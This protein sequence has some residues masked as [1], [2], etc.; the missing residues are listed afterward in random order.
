MSIGRGQV[1]TKAKVVPHYRKLVAIGNARCDAYLGAHT[2]TVD[3][4]GSTTSKV[5]SRKE[6]APV[7]PTMEI[8]IARV[9]VQHSLE[10]AIQNVN[11][12]ILLDVSMY[13]TALKTTYAQKWSQTR[14]E[15]VADTLNR[16][17]EQT[18]CSSKNSAD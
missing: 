18:A 17:I 10:K 7:L 12:G 1:G 4:H 15:N 2:D 3:I 5:L 9:W 8:R 6:T 16:Y 11:G 14:C 13:A